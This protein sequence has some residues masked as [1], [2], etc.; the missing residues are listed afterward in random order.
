M[1]QYPLVATLVA[2]LQTAPVELGKESEFG[3]GFDWDA[4]D[5]SDQPVSVEVTEFI[6]RPAPGAS[7]AEVRILVENIPLAAGENDFP[8]KT[9]LK[10]VPVGDYLVTARIQSAAGTWSD[11]SAP[12]LQVVV[13]SKKPRAPANLRRV[14][15]S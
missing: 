15:D 12:P 6:F 7:V 14:G 10:T 1:I 9:T 11:E 5:I 2:A 4:K 3:L 8:L 13:T